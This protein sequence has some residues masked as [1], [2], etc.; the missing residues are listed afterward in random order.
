M[1]LNEPFKIKSHQFP[2]GQKI[3]A[4]IGAL[5]GNVVATHKVAGFTSH[6]GKRLC[7]WCDVMDTNIAEMKIGRL[8]ST[9]ATLSSA[10]EWF[11]ATAT[12]QKKLVR[13]TGVRLSEL[14]RLSYWDP[15]NNVVLG[16]M[17]N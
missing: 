17:H 15:V 4:R 3:T 13:K 16:V 1:K 11:D 6:S 5:I 8:R 10:Q 9:M 14:N 2:E 12:D 7:S